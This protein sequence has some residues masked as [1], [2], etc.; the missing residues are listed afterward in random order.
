MKRFKSKKSKTI[1]PS[2][3]LNTFCS[4]DKEKADLLESKYEYIYFISKLDYFEIEKVFDGDFIQANKL[5]YF[6]NGKEFDFNRLNHLSIISIQKQTF[7]VLIKSI[8][9]SLNRPFEKVL[10]ALGIRNV[11]ETVAKKNM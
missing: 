8:S 6:L 5:Y 11:G 7:D 9:D 4:I 10:F 2:T 3:F 1:S